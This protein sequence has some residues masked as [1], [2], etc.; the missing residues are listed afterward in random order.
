[1]SCICCYPKEIVIY[2]KKR[3]CNICNIFLTLHGHNSNL[4]ASFVSRHIVGFI[5][6]TRNSAISRLLQLV[7][8][9]VE[10][11]VVI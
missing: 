9:V 7:T 3:I 1:M 11:L 8:G 6:L 5:H 2:I 10:H 4:L